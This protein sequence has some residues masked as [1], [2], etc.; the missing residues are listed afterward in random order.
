MD[1][2]AWAAV[3]GALRT[4]MRLDV[5]ANN[6]AN[7][8]TN[9]YKENDITFDSYLTGPGPE[10][11][12][13]PDQSFL[14]LRGPGDIPFP[15]SSP[16]TNAIA[17]TYPAAPSTVTKVNQG[18]LQLTSNP[19]D[20]AIEGDGFFVVNTPQGR[21]YTRDGAFE[22]NSFGEL[23]NKDGFQV[24]GDN[25]GPLVIGSDP[26]SIA[27]DGTISNK[28]GTIGRLL[29]VGLPEESLKRAGRNL[30]EVP[31]N[32]VTDLTDAKGGFHQG[33]LEASNANVVRGM[34]QM[35][36]AN[37]AF[38]SYMKAIQSLDGLDAQANQIGRL[39]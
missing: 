21:R 15:F 20:V 17:I 14:G 7:V 30:F 12:P 34:T 18:A 28:N 23:V 32:Q 13:M 27:K 9:G 29:R 6:L 16:A 38:E 3:N 10:Q 8:S 2:G 19:L 24:F 22:V 1:S 25:E 35:I 39:G 26:I 31:D 37:R 4:E 33:Y 11:F 36:D 5:L